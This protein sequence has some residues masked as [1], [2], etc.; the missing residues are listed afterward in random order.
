MVIEP[1]PAGRASL[2]ISKEGQFSQQKQVQDEDEGAQGD[3]VYWSSW[4][5]AV[6]EAEA[7]VGIGRGLGHGIQTALFAQTQALGVLTD[8]HVSLP[9]VLSKEK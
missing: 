6:R 8:G 3:A 1:A 2:W 9:S 5:E 7:G 4:W